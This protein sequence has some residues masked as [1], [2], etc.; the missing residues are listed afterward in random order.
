MSGVV[1]LKKIR[2][3]AVCSLT[4]C[5]SQ[6]YI[7]RGGRMREIDWDNLG[8]DINPADKMFI[9]RWKNG[10]WDDGEITDYQ[11]VP[12]YPS[13][14]VLNYGQGIFEGMKAYRT[15][16]DRI[17]LFRP[18]ENARRLNSGCGRL[19]MPEIDENFFIRAI[20]TLLLENKDYV[21]PY[22][23]GSLYIRPI[24]FGSGQML[25]VSP[26]TEYTFI[27]FMSPVGPYFKG[28]FTGIHLEIRTDY[29]RAPLFGTGNIKAIGNYATSLFP[30]SVV[31]EK[32]YTEVIYLDA[33]ASTYI[34]EVG[35]ANFFMLKDNVLSTPRL[36]GSILPGVT[37]DSVLTLARRRFK[38]ITLE[39]DIRYDELYDADELFCT[40]TAAV[41]TPIAS[42]FFEG[43]DHV[44][45]DGSPGTVSRKLYTELKGIQ[46]GEM[47]DELGWLYPV[48]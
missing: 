29:H 11:P 43:E 20:K 28:E 38:I 33:R 25:G 35:A 22:A 9:A 23:K 37:R 44:I 6:V 13:A 30:K 40:G 46:L 32:G 1:T 39:R 3:R 45:G 42:I 4:G 7:M 24:L 26:A 48:E 5:T 31:K 36:S 41:I 47:P 12:I 19:L 17:V 2:S 21:P 14:V 34:E 18:F 10:T 15:K 16:D 27:I 8:F